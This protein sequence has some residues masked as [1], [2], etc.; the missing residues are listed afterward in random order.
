MPVYLSS[1]QHAGM[2]DDLIKRS[3]FTDMR[4]I[5]AVCRCSCLAQRHL[6]APVINSAPP[7]LLPA[8]YRTCLH[9]LFWLTLLWSCHN[10][11]QLHALTMATKR[12]NQLEMKEPKC[13]EFSSGFRQRQIHGQS[14]GF[15]EIHLW[16]DAIHYSCSYWRFLQVSTDGELICV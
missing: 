7:S 15:V 11:K 9:C 3:H 6:L 12:S 16:I 10:K 5:V 4:Q 14:S 13:Q 1:Q 8:H 2:I